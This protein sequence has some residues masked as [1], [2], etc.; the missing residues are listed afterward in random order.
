MHRKSFTLSVMSA[1]IGIG[2]LAAFPHNASPIMSRSSKETS[3]Q[4]FSEVRNP[5]REGDAK[6][7]EILSAP[8]AISEIRSA[9][10]G[11]RQAVLHKDMRGITRY[12]WNSPDIVIFDVVPP[13]SYVG[14]DSFRK[15]WLGFFD[16]FKEITI[17]DFSD[18]H[19]EAEGRLG[20]MRTFVHLVGR[21]QDGKILDLTTRDTAIF[22]RI[23]GKW[24]AVHDHGSVPIIFETGQGMMNASPR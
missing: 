11:Y 1:A 8:S 15:D 14:W 6:K 24:V 3:S 17:F 18:L 22:E 13:L 4:V 5:N 7:G 21:F 2:C 9:I 23:N 19:V 20:W 16:S 10:E 12:Y